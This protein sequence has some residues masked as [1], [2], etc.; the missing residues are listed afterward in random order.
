MTIGVCH[1]LTKSDMFGCQCMCPNMM[2]C[3]ELV[4][5]VAIT[6]LACVCVIV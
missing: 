1:C 4:C 2:T 3:D 5:E 6:W